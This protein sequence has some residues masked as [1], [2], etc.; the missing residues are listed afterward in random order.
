MISA[1]FRKQRGS[2]FRPYSS[3]LEEEFDELYPYWTEK[4]IRE[5]LDIS[6][7]V[8]RQLKHNAKLKL[9][10][11]K[12]KPRE[13]GFYEKLLAK[14]SEETEADE[15]E[16]VQQPVVKSISYKGADRL[17]SRYLRR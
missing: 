10:K 2:V 15:K 3:A 9:I 8:Y 1:N 13:E 7:A 5:K 11:D 6:R 12:F 14:Q 16:E 4:I 17:L